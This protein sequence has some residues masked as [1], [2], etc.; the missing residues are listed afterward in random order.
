MVRLLKLY[1]LRGGVLLGI[2]ALGSK[3]LG[4]WRDRLVVSTFSPESSDLV[5]AAFRI[6]DFFYYLLVGATVSV[7]FLPRL[8]GLSEREKIEYM[9][10][11]LWGVLVFFGVLSAFCFL[12]APVL[13]TWFASGFSPDIQQGVSNL[14]RFLFGSVFLLSLSS[15]FAAAL[16]AQQRFVSIALAPLFYMGFIALGLYVFKDYFGVNIV[17]YG[18]LAGAITHLLITSGAYFLTGQRVALVWKKPAAA[19][20]NFWPDFGRRVFNNAAFQINQTVD[21]LI[22]SFLAIGAVTSFTLGTNLGHF[23]LSIVGLSVANSAFP[24]LA[25]AKHNYP[26]QRKILLSSAKWI[27]FFCAP[28][29]VVCAVFST[30][31][32]QL[33][34]TLENERLQMA[35][36][37]FFWTVISLPLTCVLPLLARVFL[38]NDDTV[39]PLYATIIS[40]VV[41]TS[42]A[43]YLSLVYLPKDQAILGLALGNFVANTLGFILFISLIWWKYERVH[44]NN[45]V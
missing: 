29:A 31:I 10:S 43:A 22:A 21:I 25:N 27:F 4:L 41:A 13:A 2:S 23:L 28:A 24:K 20:L 30:Q 14:A 8:V 44:K 45:H 33:L 39:S 9:S 15:V 11:F 16:Q 7:I 32:L 40:L 26:L 3:F 36:V 19:W 38:A 37:V 18:A 35:Q 42:T 17:G 5:Y 12:M 34:F 1:A 6:P